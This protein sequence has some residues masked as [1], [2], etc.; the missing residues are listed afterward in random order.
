M[1]S[2]TEDKVLDFGD[3]RCLSLQDGR[4][5][6]CLKGFVE[7]FCALG[8]VKHLKLQFAAFMCWVLMSH[9][10]GDRDIK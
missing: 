9:L 2:V 3:F 1:K 10:R 4:G 5:A 7:A 8:D 6:I